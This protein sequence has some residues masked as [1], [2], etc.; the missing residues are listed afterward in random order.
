MDVDTREKLE[1]FDNKL[2]ENINTNLNSTIKN[3]KNR[4][5]SF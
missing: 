5:K 3:K 4:T 2:D 1:L